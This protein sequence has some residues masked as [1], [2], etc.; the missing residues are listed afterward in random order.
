MAL[1]V[2]TVAL[3]YLDISAGTDISVAI[4]TFEA[5]DV[6]VVYGNAAVPA[7]L[8]TDFQ[9]TLAADFSTFTLTPLQA[10]VD[11]IDALA[12]ADA[13]ESNFITVRRTLDYETEATADGVRYTPFT[14][15]EFDRTAMR[16]QQLA[17][18]L[19]RTLRLSDKF[20]SPFPALTIAAYEEGRALVWGPNGELLNAAVGEADIASDV[21]AAE[22]AQ[23]AAVNAKTAAETAR[24]KAQDWAEEVEDTEVDTGQYSALHHSAKAS[25]QRVL[26]ET[27][28]GAAEVAETGA[29]DARAATALLA[30]SS[31]AYSNTTL[32]AA[33]TAAEA[34][35]SVGDF[36]TASADDV[37]YIGLY[38]IVSGPSSTERHR[39]VAAKTAS[40]FEQNER[41]FGFMNR[42]DFVANEVEGALSVDLETVSHSVWSVTGSGEID[43]TGVLPTST[44]PRAFW[45]GHRYRAGQVV[46]VETEV[47]LN[48]GYTSSHGPMLAFGGDGGTVKFLIYTDTGVLALTSSAMV[49]EIAQTLPTAMQFTHGEKPRLRAILNGDGTGM[50]EAIAP[51][52]E[53]SRMKLTGVPTAGKIC[54][55]WRRAP[56]AGKITAFSVKDY[57]ASAPDQWADVLDKLGLEG[58]VLRSPVDDGVDAG[59]R[60]LFDDDQVTV[61]VAP[62][63]NNHHLKTRYR[64]TKD[65]AWEFF[66]EVEMT[67]ATDA[68][69]F[70]ALIAVG[71]ALNDD[72]ARRTY[73]Y[74]ENGF[75]G[76][77][78]NSAAGVT[79]EFAVAAPTFSQ[80]DTVGLRLF[81]LR[82]GSGFLEAIG[83]SGARYRRSVEN[84]PEGAVW[85]GYRSQETG[86]IHRFYATT[87]TDEPLTEDQAAGQLVL[88]GT[89]NLPTPD[90][91]SGRSP[92][93]FTCTG[94]DVFD[95][96]SLSGLIAASDDGRLSEGDSSPFNRAI[97]ILTPSFGRVVKTLELDTQ[98]L[99][100]AQGVAIDRGLYLGTLWVCTTSGDD[101]I[102]NYEPPSLP[103][104]GGAETAT[105]TASRAITWGSGGLGKSGTP[106]GLAFDADHGSALWVSS[107]SAAEAVQ[108][109]IA[110]KSI[111]QTITLGANPDQLQ[112][113][114]ASRMSDGQA[115][116]VYTTGGN[117]SD[118]TVRVYNLETD[119]DAA[120]SSL[121]GSTAIEQAFYDPESNV[122]WAFNDRGYHDTGTDADDPA[123]NN[124]KFYTM[125]AIPV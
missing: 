56:S 13:T 18:K 21:A 7:A 63:T 100:S 31:G 64:R 113:L 114:S 60:M 15:K 22:A 10:L 112:F 59:T 42:D 41:T 52:G 74:L 58:D 65:A 50:A 9:V 84:V 23:V 44:S 71:D 109:S 116:L 6:E 25:A 39:F 3:K 93:G 2:E 107:A 14:A 76:R 61:A 78:D 24:D 26:A 16:F 45:S 98:S 70:G 80:N 106:N 27:A 119:E 38:E 54:S 62:A 49:N 82:D 43:M 110:G 104:D 89:V 30:A 57:D 97:H 123:D 4:P 85:I 72:S 29:E 92:A 69:A 17:E 34:A 111:L 99:S 87:T 51:S 75:I 83:P 67:S 68:Q 33:Q 46:D 32:A 19:D 86:V 40:A 1:A 5:T 95:F 28:K 117:G 73:A 20:V 122:M 37:D 118:G 102:R 121:T 48:S 90:S 124:V 12:A 108:V 105:E 8:N 55:V 79:D 66:V 36:Y 115:R 11:K 125:P 120:W 91:L 47:E 81:V 88:R 101:V 53:R 96:G 94:G 103:L 35:L 77:L